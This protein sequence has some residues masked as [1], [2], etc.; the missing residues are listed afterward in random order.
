VVGWVWEVGFL[1]GKGFCLSGVRGGLG[2]RVG[3]WR[4]GVTLWVAV[5]PR[6]KAP[7]VVVL[8]SEKTGWVVV[9]RSEK[10]CR[11]DWCFVFLVSLS[12]RLLAPHCPPVLPS[13]SAARE[14]VIAGACPAGE[15]W[16]AGFEG[17]FDVAVVLLRWVEGVWVFR[18]LRGFGVFRE[19]GCCECCEGLEC[20]AR[21]GVVS[22]VW[23]AN[24][25]FVS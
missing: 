21:V 15:V 9:S 8:P 13:A 5:F 6:G 10:T 2:G 12:R 7:W 22:V 1:G 4:V 23:V 3:G 20:F 11:R 19:S 24:L 17:C 16:V 14:H 25:F 18:V